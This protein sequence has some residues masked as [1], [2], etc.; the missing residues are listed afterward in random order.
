MVAQIIT[1]LLLVHLSYKQKIKPIWIQNFL[2]KNVLLCAISYDFRSD[3]YLAKLDIGLTGVLFC[4]QW[5]AV[6]ST[7][8]SMVMIRIAMEQ[9]GGTHV[10]KNG[11]AGHKVRVMVVI[12]E[13]T[14]LVNNGIFKANS[15]TTLNISLKFKYYTRSKYGGLPVITYIVNQN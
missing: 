8:L 3:N 1:F 2:V 4:Q 13:N 11:I 9:R 7:D 6:Q 14:S 10:M 12:W 15:P 5:G